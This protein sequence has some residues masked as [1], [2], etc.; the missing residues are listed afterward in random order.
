VS[1]PSAPRWFKHLRTGPFYSQKR[2]CRYLV[3]VDP[4]DSVWFDYEDGKSVESSTIDV[5]E[6][7]GNVKRRGL[8]VSAA[9]AEAYNFGDWRAKDA[10]EEATK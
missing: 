8:W 9:P 1:R 6:V 7:M 5:R 3:R 2:L 10:A 4:D